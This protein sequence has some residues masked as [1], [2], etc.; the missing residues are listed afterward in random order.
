MLEKL[1]IYDFLVFRHLLRVICAS[2]V[3]KYKNI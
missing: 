2:R 3:I 1:S